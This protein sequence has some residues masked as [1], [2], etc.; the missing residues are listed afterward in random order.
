MPSLS[1]LQMRD[2]QFRP[3]LASQADAY[4]DRLEALIEGYGGHDDALRVAPALLL[5]RNVIV[6]ILTQHGTATTL[7]L[8]PRAQAGEMALDPFARAV[9]DKERQG[10]VWQLRDYMRWLRPVL[11]GTSTYGFLDAATRT[12]M[13]AERALIAQAITFFTT[14]PSV[15]S[16]QKPL[17]QP[18]I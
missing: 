10:L 6:Q 14:E 1:P 2:E 5:E 8:P 17:E 16:L 18:A 9:R 11:D 13:D 12:E 3:R 4:L 15:A 7:A